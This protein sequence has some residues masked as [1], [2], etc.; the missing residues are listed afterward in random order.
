MKKYLCFILVLLVCGGV[1]ALAEGEY[2]LY[3]T[4][5]G[6]LWIES[7]ARPGAPAETMPCDILYRLD[8]TVE[9]ESS[10]IAAGYLKSGEKKQLLSAA[11]V[12]EYARNAEKIT[13]TVAGLF[14]FSEEPDWNPSANKA[15]YFLFENRAEYDF[16]HL[17]WAVA[18]KSALVGVL[19]AA[20]PL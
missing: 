20:A 16:S 4:D 18:A 9:W 12:R 8:E 3:F 14:G 2:R 17:P 13:F 1:S 10:L 19:Y 7:H 11:Q 5:V 15:A 6:D